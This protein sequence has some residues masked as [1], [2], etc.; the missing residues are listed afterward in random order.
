MQLSNITIHSEAI[1]AVNGDGDMPGF[2]Y[3]ESG[4]RIARLKYVS[5]DGWRGYYDA[6]PVKK[7]GYKIV[8][9]SWV[10]GNWDDAPADHSESEVDQWI[11]NYAN[12]HPAEDIRV[13]FTPTSNVFSTSYTVISK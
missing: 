13:I 3:D 4:Q 11:T 10:T 1:D 12:E 2:I 5:T 8:K 7:A 9:E 6:I